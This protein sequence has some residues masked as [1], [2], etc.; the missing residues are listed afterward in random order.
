MSDELSLQSVIRIAMTAL[1]NSDDFSDA[2]T[3]ASMMLF[4]SYITEHPNSV[5]SC[6]DLRDLGIIIS[7]IMTSNF[8]EEYP[9]YNGISQGEVLCAVGF[10]AYMEQLKQGT[11]MN[12]HYPAFVL[13]LHHG[14]KYLNN[15]YEQMLMKN[16][17]LQ[18]MSAYNPFDR[19][20]YEDIANKVQ[21]QTKAFEYIMLVMGRQRCDYDDCFNK[22]LKELTIE[23]GMS[24]QTEYKKYTGEAKKIHRYIVDDLMSDSP[25]N[26]AKR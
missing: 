5:L 6:D 15:I 18:N 7:S 8:I 14:R 3:T 24:F 20:E 22:W 26:Y 19:F 16:A 13:L 10:Y 21:R 23:F 25:F 4:T 11:L 9:T 17:G 2:R 12:N 1:Q